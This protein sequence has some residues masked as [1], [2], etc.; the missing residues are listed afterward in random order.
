MKGIHIPRKKKERKF[1][2]GII[3]V[4]DF[5]DTKLKEALSKLDYYLKNLFKN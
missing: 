3:K 1:G 5:D 4:K 2:I